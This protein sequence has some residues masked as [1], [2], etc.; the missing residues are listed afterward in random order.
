MDK[1]TIIYFALGTLLT[2]PSC[3]QEEPLGSENRSKDN[4]IYFR[5][6]LPE[7]TPT[8]AQVISTDNFTT[9]QV[10]CFNP[11]DT[12]LIDLASGEVKEYFRNVTFEKDTN[13][14]FY[15]KEDTTCVWPDTES[16]LHF[17]AFYPSDAEMK[18]TSGDDYFNLVNGSK[19]T[20]GKFS[21]DYKL[22]H[23]RVANNIA[24]Q[25]DFLTAYS[26]GTL[27]KNTAS[28]GITLDFKHQLSRI[29]LTAWGENEKYDFEIAGIR[30]G[31]PLAEATFNFSSLTQ[32]NSVYPWQLAANPQASIEYI[33]T[34]GDKVV[35]LGKTSGLHT[36]ENDAISIMG[37]AGPAMV[38]PNQTK[39]E[40]WEGKGDPNITAEH[41]STDKMYFSVLL[42]VINLDNDVVYP[43]SNNRDD[44][45]VIYFVIDKQG[46]EIKKRLY[47]IGNAY[48]TEKEKKEDSL[49][50]PTD[51]EKICGF[52][53]AALPVDAKWEA[54]KIYTYKLNYSTG[55]GWHDPDDPTPGEPIIERGSIPFKVQV[56]EW[57]R[58]DDFNSNLDVPKR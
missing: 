22:E 3:S 38:I 18:K 40:A 25:V 53:W 27:E 19:K 37:S 33:F 44:M 15:A 50:T 58:A 36:S 28:S 31:N 30:I 23:F 20:E 39:I 55:I 46:G 12:N 42:R 54:G 43:Y 57:L 9:C 56:E 13:G 34:G 47:K 17:F 49:Y 5:S 51:N 10:T 32:G 29:E 2:I 41:Y 7:V 11:D 26:T 35:R 48:Y 16:T 52:G 8:R 14:K 45:T 1:K 21:I 24:D 4:R 6:Y